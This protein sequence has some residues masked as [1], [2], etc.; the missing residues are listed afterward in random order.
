ML[1]GYEIHQPKIGIDV[2][3]GDILQIQGGIGST[4]LGIV[5][6]GLAGY[7]L[8]QVGDDRGSD[9]PAA[10]RGR[11]DRVFGLGP[12]LGIL[13]PMLRAKLGIRYTRDFGVRG[14]PEGQL[15]VVGLSFRVWA[16]P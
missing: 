11:R 15:V 8:W 10:L 5:D 13:M 1:V 7:A 9:L 6:L 4:V 12:E 16:Q 2:T 14:R 3:R